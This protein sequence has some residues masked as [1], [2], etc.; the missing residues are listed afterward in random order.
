MT[1]EI[2]STA[3]GQVRGTLNGQLA[4]PF[5]GEKLGLGTYGKNGCGIIALYNALQLLGRPQP[6]GE[7]GADFVRHHRL[8]FGGLGGHPAP[9]HRRLFPGTGSPLRGQLFLPPPG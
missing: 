8:L 6:L 9:V 5:A 2:A 3:A 7:I 4:L 1:R